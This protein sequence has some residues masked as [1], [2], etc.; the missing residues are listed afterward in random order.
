MYSGK[1]VIL[2]SSGA[3]AF[4]RQRLINQLLM[5]QSVRQTLR[6]IN[7]HQ[8]VINPRACAG[9]GQSGLMSLYEAM[10]AQYGIPCAQVYRHFCFPIN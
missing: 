7:K 3:V 5:G 8:L 9:A 1:E 10:F 2:V 6:D 4:G